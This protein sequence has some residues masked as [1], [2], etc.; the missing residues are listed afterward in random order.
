MDLSSARRR[1]QRRDPR[2]SATSHHLSSRVCLSV[3]VAGLVV[4]LSGCGLGGSERQSKESAD[5]A[6]SAIPGVGEATVNTE[7]LISGLQI[8][9]S[10]VIELNLEP[11][12]SVSDPERLVDYLLRVAWS[13]Q[14]KE[15]NRAV[16]V[17]IV[18]EPQISTLDALDAGG[19]ESARGRSSRPERSLVRTYEVKERYGDWPGEVPELPE[20]LI[21]GPT[22]KPTS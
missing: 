13:T 9:T 5:A 8:E 17:Q 10:T 21:I 12:S 16:V 11:G 2:M 19:W 4:I 20:S 3:A 22:S 15:A 7:S 18:G 6:L 1:S 14:T